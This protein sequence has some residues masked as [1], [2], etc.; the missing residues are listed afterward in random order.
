[1]IRA[2][3]FALIAAPLAGCFVHSRTDGYVE[4]SYPPSDPYA[5][6]EVNTAPPPP[7]TEYRPYPPAPGYVWVDGYWDWSGYDWTWAN[8]YWAPPR[9]G[10]YYVRPSYVVVGGRYRY[11]RGYWR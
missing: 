2:V 3:L 5:Q 4:D 7:V 9:G 11:N 1:M 6:V 10:Y 8:G